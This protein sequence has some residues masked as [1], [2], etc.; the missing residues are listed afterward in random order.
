MNEKVLQSFNPD[1]PLR[2]SQMDRMIHFHLNPGSSDWAIRAKHIRG[3]QRHP[4][5]KI[6]VIVVTDMVGPQGPMGYEVTEGFDW[7]IE[8]YTAALENRPISAIM[9]PANKFSSGKIIS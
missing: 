3:F 7:C 9:N 6:S 1:Q 5:N 2:P 8:M 4:E